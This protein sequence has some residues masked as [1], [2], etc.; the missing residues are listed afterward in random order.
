MYSYPNRVIAASQVIADTLPKTK[1]DQLD[2]TMKEL[3]IDL[4]KLNVEMK[5]LNINLDKQLQSLADIDI[6]AIQK[7]TETSLKQINWDKMQQDVNV[8]VEKAQNEIAK[9]ETDT[10]S[11]TKYGQVEC[12]RR[13]W[14]CCILG[15]AYR[16]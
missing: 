9:I 2:K 16:R 11:T 8:S 10:P 14:R 4:S 13:G 5:E 6:D 7:Q 1:Q 15:P 3:D 12:P